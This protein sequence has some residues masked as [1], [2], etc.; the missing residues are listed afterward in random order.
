MDYLLN[1]RLSSLSGVMGQVA[2]LFKKTKDNASA[3]KAIDLVVANDIVDEFYNLG[4]VINGDRR[5]VRSC[6]RLL[7]ATCSWS[8]QHHRYV[9]LMLCLMLC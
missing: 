2:Y 6:Q 7:V 1:S 9:F 8:Q 5:E 4:K 3:R